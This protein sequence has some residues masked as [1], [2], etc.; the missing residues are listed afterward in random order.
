MSYYSRNIELLITVAKRAALGLIRD[1]TELTQLQSAPKGHEEFT[2]AAIDRTIMVLRNELGKFHA[3]YPIINKA[4]DLPIT[5]CFVVNPLDGKMN[6]MHGIPYFATTIAIVRREK[7]LSSVI[8][9][10]ATG[11]TFWAEQGCGAFKE[12]SRNNL[13]LRV[14]SRSDLAKSLIATSEQ[15]LCEH[16]GGIRNFGSMSLDLAAVAGGQ[17]DGLVCSGKCLSDI[18]A[19]LLLVKESG[20]RNLSPQQEDERLDDVM[21]IWKSGNLISGN[22]TICSKLFDLA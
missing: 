17:F 19:G 5:E 9:N 12:A 1:F 10:A 14:S 3:D 6:F 4:E 21:S 20:G 22:P 13:R 8:Y 18:A 7:V 2:Q 15:K 11:D 16:V